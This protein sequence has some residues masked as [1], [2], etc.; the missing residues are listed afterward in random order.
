MQDLQRDRPVVPKV[1]GEIHSGH[2]ATP[3]LTLDAVAIRKAAPE[4]LG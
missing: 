3:K 4:L 2:A 1:V